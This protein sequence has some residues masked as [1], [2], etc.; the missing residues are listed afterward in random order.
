MKK[1]CFYCDDI[2]EFKC[3]WVNPS[4]GHVTADSSV[5]TCSNCVSLIGAQLEKRFPH[6]YET[7]TIVEI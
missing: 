5:V 6:V 2:P 4:V 3:T 1:K 7:F